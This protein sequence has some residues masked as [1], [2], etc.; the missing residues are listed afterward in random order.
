MTNYEVTIGYRAVIIVSAKAENE[1]DAKEKAIE[2]FEKARERL[3]DS[4]GIHIQTDRYAADGI[5]NLDE[6]WNSIY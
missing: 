1:E 4:K 2:T 6:T 3:S 5:V